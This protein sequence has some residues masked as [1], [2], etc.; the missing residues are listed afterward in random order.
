[1]RAGV[2]NGSMRAGVKN[3]IHSLKP[4]IPGLNNENTTIGEYERAKIPQ[5]R[6][7]GISLTR[8]TGSLGVEL[9]Q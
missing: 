1:M 6:N 8:A 2:I 5:R 3:I 4:A 7:I 9:G